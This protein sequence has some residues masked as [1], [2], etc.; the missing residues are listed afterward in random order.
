MYQL[1]TQMFIKYIA[2]QAR[3][4]QAEAER[5]QYEQDFSSAAHNVSLSQHSNVLTVVWN[6]VIDCLSAPLQGLANRNTAL[7]ESRSFSPNEKQVPVQV[8]VHNSGTMHHLIRP[9]SWC[10]LC[11]P[12]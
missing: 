5:G 2:R 11:R 1:C 9:A 3:E 12:S 7:K 4:E 6:I 10:T 8:V